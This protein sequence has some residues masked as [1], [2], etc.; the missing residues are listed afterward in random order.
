MK[1]TR[2][3]FAACF[4]GA[5]LGA[6]S[7][8]FAVLT[9]GKFDRHH[10]F[11]CQRGS[12]DPQAGQP[13]SA[14]D[15]SVP[16]RDNLEPYHLASGEYVKFFYLGGAC[17][18]GAVGLGRYDALGNFVEAISAAGS[19][20][21]LGSEGL[22]YISDNGDVGTFIANAGT[23]NYGDAVTYTPIYGKVEDCA[24][25]NAYSPTTEVVPF[26]ICPATPDSCNAP[27][28]STITVKTGSDP[29][30]NLFKWNWK[31]GDVVTEYF[32]SPDYNV[33]QE[34]DLCVYD[35]NND[36]WMQGAIF[37]GGTCG[38][39]SCWSSNG[40]VA[41]YK[42][43]IPNESGITGVTA[44]TVIAKGAISMSGKGANLAFGYL[45]IYPG[46]GVTVQLRVS[47]GVCWSSNFALKTNSATG[48][49]GK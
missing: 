35:G 43:K 41:K 16:Y 20:W 40:V 42:S 47:P 15:L 24:V 25:L 29:S 27:L 46:G 1:N 34:F 17:A 48:F 3:I 45:P 4:F 14:S 49:S 12:S 32:G 18:N 7:V 23:Y 28:T 39:K 6:S 8:A 37:G 26:E 38:K 2:L 36:L 13:F 9:D 5:L 10:V 44:K 19:V 21:G 33:L 22:L 31:T 11:D 30:K